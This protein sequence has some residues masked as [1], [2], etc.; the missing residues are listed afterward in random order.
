MSFIKHSD[1]EISHIIK[2]TDDIDVEKTSKVLK[3]AKEAAKN[4]NKDGNKTEL[5]KE[6]E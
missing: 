1:G 5:S 2:S 6:S 3:E 4:L